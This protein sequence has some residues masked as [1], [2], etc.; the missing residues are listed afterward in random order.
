LKRVK[1]EHGESSSTNPEGGQC[2]KAI[3]VNLSNKNIIKVSARK[4]KTI[5][6]KGLFPFKP[7][8]EVR[9]DPTKGNHKCATIWNEAKPF[10]TNGQNQP[11]NKYWH[12]QII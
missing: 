7:P 8:D 3:L 9:I 6:D 11:K 2:G 5:M 1:I 12:H 10:F 4:S